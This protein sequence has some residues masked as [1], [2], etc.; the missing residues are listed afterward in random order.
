MILGVNVAST[1][2]RMDVIFVPLLH[3]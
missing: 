1:A 3:L 2:T